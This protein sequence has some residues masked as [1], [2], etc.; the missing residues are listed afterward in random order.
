MMACDRTNEKLSYLYNPI[1]ISVLRVL[2]RVIETANKNNKAITL[3]GEM[4][5]VAMYTPVLL[6]L[7]IREL[8][9]SVTSIA[10]I[11]NLI[12]S[13]SIEEC[14]KLV[15]E[16]LEKCDNNFSKS[17]LNSFIKKIDIK[18]YKGISE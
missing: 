9:M 7:G 4:A 5:S 13:I 16:M 17:I 10:K 1:D 11:K 3:C 12:R 18:N 15:N 6:G 8:S 2:K 14:T